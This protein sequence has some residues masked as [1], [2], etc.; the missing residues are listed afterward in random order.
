MGFLVFYLFIYFFLKILCKPQ[1]GG[2]K[3]EQNQKPTPHTK[4]QNL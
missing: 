1:L 2:E 3:K 4:I